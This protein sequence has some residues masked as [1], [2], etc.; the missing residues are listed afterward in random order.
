MAR[1]PSDLISIGRYLDHWLGTRHLKRRPL[2]ARQR[3]ARPVKAL[4][5]AGITVAQAETL[6]QGDLMQAGAGVL[7]LVTMRSMTTSTAR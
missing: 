3:L 4:Y 2:P 7:A 6:L 5:P 1:G